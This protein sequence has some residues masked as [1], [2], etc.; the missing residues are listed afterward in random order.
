MFSTAVSRPFIKKWCFDSTSRYVPAKRGHCACL[1]LPGTH[2]C[3]VHL[4]L[5]QTSKA[6]RGRSLRLLGWNLGWI[7]YDR[8][9]MA[10]VCRPSTIRRAPTPFSR[11]LCDRTRLNYCDRIADMLVYPATP[12]GAPKYV[13]IA[14]DAPSCSSA[15]AP[16]LSGIHGNGFPLRPR[17]APKRI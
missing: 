2:L 15:T 8:R 16:A 3:T 7:S 9:C 4:K 17:S 11:R 12:F 10:D 14:G 5:S 13:V 1:R 6:R